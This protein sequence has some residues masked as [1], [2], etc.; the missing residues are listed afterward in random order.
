M[1]LILLF[2]CLHFYHQNH[3]SR[4]TS[5]AR[6][7]PPLQT[8][9]YLAWKCPESTVKLW[10]PRL[11]TQE[12]LFTQTRMIYNDTNSLTTNKFDHVK[13]MLH[14]RN[15]ETFLLGHTIQGQPFSYRINQNTQKHFNSMPD[16]SRSNFKRNKRRPPQWQAPSNFHHKKCRRVSPSNE[17]VEFTKISL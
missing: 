17:N 6:N 16:N 5:T 3:I 8:S 13:I 11:Y 14:N 15:P 10:Q 4:S 7:R 1:M 12:Y 9:Y 2:V